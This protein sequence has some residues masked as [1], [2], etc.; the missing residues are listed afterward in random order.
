MNYD[1]F[2]AR[3][4]RESSILVTLDRT[5]F[6]FPLWSWQDLSSIV[7]P[8][9]TAF[10]WREGSNITLGDCVN[11]QTEIALTKCQTWCHNVIISLS[12]PDKMSNWWARCVI[13]ILFLICTAGAGLGEGAKYL[14]NLS[15]RG[16]RRRAARTVSRWYH[17]YL[18]SLTIIKDCGDQN[19]WLNWLHFYIISTCCYVS[20]YGVTPAI[21]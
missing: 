19:R 2:P 15:E 18:S 17:K 6:I 8:D 5:V 9:F 4:V 20:M 16:E 14:L 7:L 13:W 11:V 10:L 21:L 1:C 3:E 12:P